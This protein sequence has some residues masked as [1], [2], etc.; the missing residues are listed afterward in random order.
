MPLDKDNDFDY[1]WNEDPKCPFCDHEN[2]KTD[3]DIFH[4]GDHVIECQKCEK[5][6]KVVST[7]D[8]TFCTDEQED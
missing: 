6:F 2:D 3:L 8:W 7:C 1:R 4:N 5:E